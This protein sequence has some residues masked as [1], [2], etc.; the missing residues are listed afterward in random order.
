MTIR[1]FIIESRSIFAAGLHSV[2]T[3]TDGFSVAGEE[4]EGI[5][6][7]R[8]L[9][10]LDPCPEVVL[11]DLWFASEAQHSTIH[12]IASTTR[13]H[14]LAIA[15]DVDD[16]IV[17]AAVQAGAH[18]FLTSDASP[19]ELRHAIRI[20][21]AGGAA[22]SAQIT[23]RLS[24]YFSNSKQDPIRASFPELTERE[25]EIVELIA[26]GHNN[27]W[28]ARHLVLSEKTVR[29]HI[30]NIFSKLQVPDRSAAIMRARNI[31]LGT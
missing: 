10:E 22:F 15:G 11:M 17:I 21:A 18:G 29:N 30:T 7:V 2:L 13:S 25:N 27:R 24:T 4:A 16:D 26:L 23:K 12:A 20:V 3:G 6:A 19:E 9:Q 8:T 5:D 1:V 14:V 28:I 31:G